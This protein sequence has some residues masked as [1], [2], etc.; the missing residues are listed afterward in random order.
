MADPFTAT[1]VAGTGTGPIPFDQ[2]RLHAAMDQAGLDAILVTSKINVRYLTG[3]Y[4]CSFHDTM[5][6]LGISKYTPVLLYRKSHPEHSMYLGSYFDKEELANSPIWIPNADVSS[7]VGSSTPPLIADWVKKEKLDGA[8]IGIEYPFMPADI[9]L[10]LLKLL[11]GVTWADAVVPLEYLRAI[12]TPA[13]LTTLRVASEKVV[14]AMLHGFRQARPGMSSREVETLVAN[15]ERRLGMV[16]DYCMV[17]MGKDTNRCP[18]DN[19]R[20]EAGMIMDFDSGANIDGYIGDLCRMGSDGEPEPLQKKLLEE[21]DH[22]QMSARKPMKH[23]ARGGEILE[24]AMKAKDECEH[25]AWMGFIVH[26]IGLVSHEA[27]RL[28]LKPIPY[29]AEW[30]ERPLEA[31]M[32]VSIETTIAKPECGYVKLEDT[33]SVTAT[34]SEGFGDG[35]RGWNP[36]GG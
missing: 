22:V 33:V 12:K 6:S 17:G 5:D 31:G 16:F 11:P 23:G 4:H 18:R 7:W 1:A 2:N 36:I 29:P 26:G 32:V 3:G 13:E 20:F 14:E 34:G 25:G 19:M 9:Y 24:A 21:I 15:E 35:G 10:D 27:P 30:A 8:K 28:V